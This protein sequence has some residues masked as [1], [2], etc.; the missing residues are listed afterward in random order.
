M[1]VLMVIMA[2]SSGCCHIMSP[3][4]GQFYSEVSCE[5]AKAIVL[6]NSPENTVA[7]CLRSDQ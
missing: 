4:F 6:Q 7:V 2:T 3:T 5:N 1:W